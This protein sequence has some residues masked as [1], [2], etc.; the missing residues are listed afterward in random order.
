MISVF[1]L[2]DAL[3]WEVLR[4]RN[5]LSDILPYRQE[6]KTIFGFSSA[7]IPSILTGLP[8]SGHGHW[9]LYLYDPKRSPFRW[10]KPLRLLPS[11]LINHRVVR[12]AVSIIGRKVSRTDGYFQV[13]GIPVEILPFFDVCEKDNIYR[14]QGLKPSRSIFDRLEE[15]NVPYRVYSYHDYTD[16]QAIGQAVEDIGNGRAV[17]YFLYL[18]E[19]DAFLHKHVSS[20]GSVDAELGRYASA[21]R[22]VYNTAM[23]CNPETSFYVFSDHGMTPTRETFDLMG[24]IS[25]LGLC[26]PRDYV[27]LY[28]STMARFWFFSELARQSISARLGG[29]NCGAIVGPDEQKAF[30][31]DFADNRFGD[32]IFLMKPGC[33]VHPSFMGRVPWPGMH[34]FHPDDPGSSAALLA[35]RKMPIPVGNIRDMFQLMLQEAGIE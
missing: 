7:A 1:I 31:I 26:V 21:I 34:G 19:L 3:G 32:L 25:S 27:A 8:P 16:T 22:S 23:A 17:F 11:R 14:C 13:Y 30:G 6:L 20:N 15:N 24:A 5:F 35:H 4:D 9:N 10:A 2:V 29:L 12:K 18:A 28:D 33:L